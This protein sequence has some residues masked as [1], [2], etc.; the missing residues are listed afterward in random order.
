VSEAYTCAICGYTSDVRADFVELN[1]P[2]KLPKVVERARGRG[3]SV[4]A[5]DVKYIC[6]RC[7]MELYQEETRSPRPVRVVCPRCGEVIEVWL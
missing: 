7:N 4:R 5:G 2:V 1:D 3:R 6:L